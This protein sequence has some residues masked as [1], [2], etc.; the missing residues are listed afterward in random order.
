MKSS[1]IHA[2]AL[3]ASA[4]ADLAL[5]ARARATGAEV[6]ALNSCLK[7]EF[8]HVQASGWML[9]PLHAINNK[10]YFDQ[11]GNWVYTETNG[12]ARCA[13]GT[14]PMTGAAPGQVFGFCTGT[15]TGPRRT[16]GR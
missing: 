12:A 1:I 8:A 15:R 16:S 4:A 10:F 11:L 5:N 2:V 9:R 14:Q 13:R 6:C 3:A 7:G